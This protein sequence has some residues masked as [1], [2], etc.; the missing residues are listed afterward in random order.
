ML[1]LTKENEIKNEIEKLTKLT[2][3]ISFIRF[4]LFLCIVVFVVCL[5]TLDQFILFLG[6]SIVFI[7]LFASCILFTNS[8]YHK[9]KLLNNL[10]YTYKKHTN[11]R[12]LSYHSFTPDGRD[13]VDYTDYKELDLDLLGPRSLFQY[14]CVAK[15]KEGRR[16]LATQL[17]HPIVKPKDFT[18]GVLAL[19]QDE[20]SLNLE[21]SIS[22]IGADSKDCDQKEMLGIA[23]KK[24][25]ISWWLIALCI[26]SYAAFAVTLALL[27]VNHIEPY[28]VFLFIPLNFVI[29][30]KCLKSEVFAFSSTKYANLL[31]AYKRL[32]KDVLNIKMDNPYYMSLQKSIEAEYESLV[33]LSRI[34]DMLSYRKN[35]IL[36]I[37]GNGVF[38][39]DLIIAVL[40]NSFTNRLKS[41]EAC[42][43]ALS[44]L[45][46]M[47][48]LATIGIDQEVYSVPTITDGFKIVEGYHPLV[49]SCVP[50][51][52]EFK[53]GIVLTGSNMS[54]KTTFMRMLG[55]NQILANAGGLVCA[56]EF[57]T[58][59]YNVVT[60]L[61]ANDMLQEGISTFYAEVNRMKRIMEESN[62]PN[63]LVLIDEIFKGTN[64]KDR[65]YAA[66]KIIDKLNALGVYFLI[67]THDFELCDV[68]TI[69][70]YHFDE[71]YIEDKISFDYKIKD[72]K[73]QKTNAIY[74]LKLAGVLD[75]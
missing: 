47:L 58:G 74:L 12:N 49:K 53:N 57:Q 56:K 1:E 44:E 26:L 31:S 35:I 73:C 33:G 36:S 18:D 28:Y 42:L 29:T 17:T 30:K 27:L 34:F 6:L 15:S 46:L 50:N 59:P 75:N 65:I 63:T 72:G 8:Y 64:A 3:T 71:D 62:H 39:L 16:K 37:V 20:A 68:E 24:I 67:T 5:I 40:F 38:F 2:K 41:A 11:R 52:F 54:G 25:K 45:E 19:A 51:S 70:N 7:S 22:L 13:L 43:S 23:E 55:V 61:R 32:A 66:K 60:S 9:L 69:V 4:C 21:A 10:A 14:L 48:S